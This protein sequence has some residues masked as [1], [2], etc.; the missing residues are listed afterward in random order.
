MFPYL[1]LILVA[2]IT[3]WFVC[4][5]Q[6]DISSWDEASSLSVRRNKMTIFLFF[7]GLL[8][9]LMLRDITVGRD[10]IEYK[11]IFEKCAASSFKGLKKFSWE[12]GYT[13]YNKL[14]SFV[15]ED[16]RFFLIVTAIITVF[17]IYKLYAKETKHSFL[18]IV[19]FINMP[20]FLMIF[21]GLRQ[22]IAISIGILVFFALENK[23][24]VLSA[25]LLL[26]AT[27]FH[28]SAYILIL[29]YPTYFLKIKTKHLLFVIPLMIGIY[30]YRISLFKIIINVAPERYEEFYGEI[31]ET[32][33]I[34]M[35]ILF[36][37]FSIFSFVVLDE[38]SMTQKDYSLRN[39]LLIST[40]LQFFVPIHDLVQR[41]SYYFLVFVPVAILSVVKAPKKVMKDIS[42]VAIVAMSCFFVLYFFYNAAFTT[43]NLLDVFP[44]KFY[45]SNKL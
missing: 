9:L 25:L 23:K 29:I 32:G 35:M 24:Y 39:F 21:S 4:K 19:L 31:Q 33:A 10:L 20:C 38:K 34:G 5:E 14:I 18:L 37:I 12:I 13:I 6:T 8:I 45:W 41:M 26:L 15:S 43:D 44:Y 42:G 2:V 30:A 16:Y 11:K 7:A 40:M 22:A 17:P 27:C 3:P 1:L 28:T 36:L